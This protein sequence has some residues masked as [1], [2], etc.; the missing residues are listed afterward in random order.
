MSM[1]K[2]VIDVQRVSEN[3]EYF[4]KHGLFQYEIDIKL[5]KKKKTDDKKKKIKSKL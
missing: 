4:R 3:M 1:D 2:K 5:G